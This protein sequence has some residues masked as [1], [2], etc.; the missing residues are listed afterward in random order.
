M[1]LKQLFE[2]TFTEKSEIEAWLDAR[3]IND[4][5]INDDLTIDVDRALIL[6]FYDDE[7]PVSFGKVDY[8]MVRDCYNLA[9]LKGFPKEATTIKI[10]ACAIPNLVGITSKFKM[11]TIHNCPSLS[12]LKGL[13]SEVDGDITAIFNANLTSLEG[14]P[15]K[16]G[17]F[18][19]SNNSIKS[20][21]GGPKDVSGSYECNGNK[22]TSLEGAPREVNKNFVCGGNLL[23]SLKGSPREVGR[24]YVCS[25]NKLTTLKGGPKEV[26][27]VFYCNNNELEN[28]DYAPEASEIVSDFIDEGWKEKAQVAGAAALMATA[29]LVNRGPTEEPTSKSVTGAISQEVSKL[30]DVPK[31]VASIFN[32]PAKVLYKEA[33][34]AGISGVELIQLMAQSA[35][36]TGGFKDLVET[37]SKDYFLDYDPT[38]NP[39]KAKIL[40]NTKVG[41]GEKFKGRGYLQLTGRDNYM[42]AGKALGLPLETKPE[43]VE[44]P[45]IG[46]LTAIWF[47]KNRVRPKVDDFSDVK[48]VTK[49]IN[50]G[51]KG[52]EDRTRRFKQMINLYDVELKDQN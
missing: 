6:S 29:L 52:L 37:G 12:S 30:A 7:L 33:K 25:Y 36:E 50:S 46:A 8:F 18:S 4:Y 27:G 22:L 11:L 49:A 21:V 15:R 48:D 40:G 3:N 31:K 51:M 26:G 38:R 14:A 42:R 39:R 5:T 1:K 13:P 16:V 23:T 34:A 17:N 47:W 43:L 20:L 9:S 19:V 24:D 35:H 44:D 41:D 32:G 45:K 28:L 10:E 2:N